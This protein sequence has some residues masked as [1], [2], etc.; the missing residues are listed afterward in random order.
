MLGGSTVKTK[1]RKRLHLGAAIF[2]AVQIPVTPFVFHDPFEIYLVWISQ[3]ALVASHL[4]GVSA[5][6]PD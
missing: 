5:D 4:S 6:T 3:W 2:F 1:T